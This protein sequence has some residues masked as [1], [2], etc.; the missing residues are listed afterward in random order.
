MKI[1]LLWIERAPSAI[2]RILCQ[3]VLRYI[4][5]ALILWM[6][7]QSPVFAQTESVIYNFAGGMTDGANPY[8][9]LAID[10]SGNLLGTTTGGGSHNG[11]T[12]YKLSPAGLTWKE[13]L[14]Y[15]FGAALDG[16]SP[17]SGL[18][19]GSSGKLYGTTAYGGQGLNFGTFFEITPGITWT[20]TGL[21]I[22]PGDGGGQWPFDIGKLATDSDGNF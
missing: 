5:M 4:L 13:T 3:M 20:E 18:V 7:S 10:S 8:S 21:Y 11:G 12:V 19:Q 2:S 15:N 22:F 1:F 14:L 6:S 16:N 9:S 17:W